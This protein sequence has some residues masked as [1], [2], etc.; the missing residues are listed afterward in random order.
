MENQKIIKKRVYSEDEKEYF[1]K[2]YIE[3]R[4]TMVER[5]KELYPLRK[6]RE[7]IK[8]LNN[9]EYKNIPYLKMQKYNIVKN[10]ETKLYE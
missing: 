9:N 7:I 3:H 10:T 2:Y 1:K 8:K 6:R 4:D 5:F